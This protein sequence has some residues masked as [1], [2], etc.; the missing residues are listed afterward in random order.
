M[1]ITG[2]L[3][4]T[5]TTYWEPAKWAARLRALK[6]DQNLLM[7][8]VDFEAGHGGPSGRF[9]RLKEV[10]LEYAFILKAF[11]MEGV[12]GPSDP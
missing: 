6:T 8:K 4:D 5:R 2:G 1:F 3:N 7:L 9:D 10:A 11:G 12:S